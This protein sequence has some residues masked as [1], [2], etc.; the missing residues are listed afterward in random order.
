MKLQKWKMEIVIVLENF[1]AL[2]E[3]DRQD[4]Y[5]KYASL[6]FDKSNMVTEIE[7]MI[8]GEFHK[9]FTKDIFRE[10]IYLPFESIEMPVPITLKVSLLS[11]PTKRRF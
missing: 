5:R 9:I 2:K 8:K 4:F 1:H 3:K 10:T 6:L 7:Y 11:V